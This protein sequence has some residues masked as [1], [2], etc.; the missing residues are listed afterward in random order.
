MLYCQTA[1]PK[2]MHPKIVMKKSG[3][4]QCELDKVLS[5]VVA[6]AP[7]PVWLQ[8]D[9]KSELPLVPNWGRGELLRERD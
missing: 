9:A 8:V 3:R 1:M 5:P 4:R 6:H 2:P 7:S